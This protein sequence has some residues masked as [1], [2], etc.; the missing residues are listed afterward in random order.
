MKNKS[1]NFLIIASKDQISALSLE[2]CLNT[3]GHAVYRL[4]QN[5]SFL[6]YMIDKNIHGLFI[7]FN[8]SG[9]S[10]LDL[11]KTTFADPRFKHFPIAIF[12][13]DSNNSLNDAFLDIGVSEIISSPIDKSALKQ[14]CRM[15]SNM[16]SRIVYLKE[17]EEY[18]HHLEMES[19]LA[20][21]KLD[22]DFSIIEC[23]SNYQ[24]NIAEKNNNWQ[25]HLFTDY[26]HPLDR[27]TCLQY[28]TSAQG[29]PDPI[30]FCARLRSVNEYQYYSWT[31]TNNEHYSVLTGHNISEQLSADDRNNMNAKIFQEAR[32]ISQITP[33][34]YNPISQEL[35][36]GLDFTFQNFGHTA[37]FSHFIKT[38]IDEDRPKFQAAFHNFVQHHE[39]FTIS[40]KQYVNKELR[41]LF[42][43]GFT[44]SHTDSGKAS[45]IGIIQDI[46]YFNEMSHELILQKS[47]LKNVDKVG[48][49]GR[50][51]LDLKSKQVIIS[52]QLHELIGFDKTP[53]NQIEKVLPH[54]HPDDREKLKKFIISYAQRLPQ[55]DI[56]ECRMFNSVK[57]IKHVRIY[58]ES[59]FNPDTG[60]IIS[61]YG[62]V[63]DISEIHKVKHELMIRE[64]DYKTLFHN[65][66]NPH[67]LA[68]I[69]RDKKGKAY[70]I[71]IIEESLSFKNIFDSKERSLV[72]K[73]YLS[74]TSE[75]SAGL[76]RELAILSLKEDYYFGERY[77]ALTD[78]WFHISIYSPSKDKVIWSLNDISAI[79]KNGNILKQKNR[80]S[81]LLNTILKHI[82]EHI[83]YKDMLKKS[84]PLI[85]DQMN[86]TRV[87]FFQ[88]EKT[89]KNL[90]SDFSYSKT[91]TK[92]YL[93]ANSILIMG[94]HDSVIPLKNKQGLLIINDCFN[95]NLVQTSLVK[96]IK[97]GPIRSLL[98][99]PLIV[100]QSL[101]GYVGV[102]TDHA[103][104][105]N[106]DEISLIENIGFA[107]SSYLEKKMKSDEL[108]YEQRRL[109]LAL[110]INDMVDWEYRVST[111][112]WTFNEHYFDYI[113]R[114]FPG[115]E[116]IK[117]PTFEFIH[118]EDRDKFK[119]DFF[120]FIHGS[121]KVFQNIIRIQTLKKEIKWIYFVANVSQRLAN[122]SPEII[123]GIFQ[124]IT[125]EYIQRRKLEI[126][127]DK[128]KQTS[129]LA[130]IGYWNYS[131]TDKTFTFTA[132]AARI[133]L[134]KR[135]ETIL[136]YNDFITMVPF[137]DRERYI[138]H[139]MAKKSK[140]SSTVKYHIITPKGKEK[141]IHEIRLDDFNSHGYYVT[142][143]G[144]IQDMSEIE[145]VSSALQL[146]EAR[147]TNAI[148][149]VNM[150]IWEYN[151]STKSFVTNHMWF[152]MLGYKPLENMTIS[153]RFWED[154][155]HPEDKPHVLQELGKFIS[156][157]ISI[158]D[159][160]Y[161]MRSHDGSYRWIHSFAQSKSLTSSNIIGFHLDVSDSMRQHQDLEMANNLIQNTHDA[162]YVLDMNGNIIFVNQAV[163][164]MLGYSI[165]SI[166]NMTIMDLDS[167]KE[168]NTIEQYTKRWESRILNKTYV[169]ETEHITSTGKTIPV[170]AHV[171]HAMVENQELSFCILSDITDQKKK[172]QELIRAKENAEIANKAKSNF[173]A[174][175]SHEI[176]TP[177]NA[178]IGYSNLLADKLNEGEMG[179]Y[180]KSI[181]T[182]G[183]NL[184]TLINNILDISK[185]EAQKVSLKEKP[186]Q[187]I[188]LLQE[189]ETIFRIRAEKKMLDF[190]IELPS[191][192]PYL[193]LDRIRIQQILTNLI[194]NAIKFTEEG[195]I[196]ISLTLRQNM[197]RLYS[198]SINVTDT[199]MGIDPINQKKIFQTFEQTDM[200]SELMI[201]GSGLGLSISKQLTELMGGTLSCKSSLGK[202]STFSI[203]L[204]D[205]KG[206]EFKNTLNLLDIEPNAPKI[207]LFKRFKNQQEIILP[208]KITKKE[209]DTLAEMILKLS[210]G[211]NIQ[212]GKKCVLYL[213]KLA[214][215]Y[216]DE[217]LTI[218][219]S[220]LNNSLST[221]DIV[222]IDKIVSEY[223]KAL[224]L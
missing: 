210:A 187:L 197:N 168:L 21:V 146:S 144:V 60:K 156:Q 39:D 51:T 66:H 43:R 80:N 214:K 85:I 196:R 170:E 160:T 129:L 143:R 200:T 184:L 199:G 12:G 11:C 33:W 98:Y 117:E 1:L 46:S 65:L 217:N 75:K 16:V 37:E 213:K 158:Y 26:I 36:F 218:N 15:F 149:G 220:K 56:I 62:I 118:P 76:L 70:D 204:S 180:T 73:N 211:I 138:Q 18:F 135:K 109:K 10:S 115:K 67:L 151:V 176:R 130:K 193:Q 68:Q 77:Y 145:E 72:G 126:S 148:E 50:W 186:V 201:K 120:E 110:Q 8:I 61:V 93:D 87:D 99:A 124:E 91:D 173:I 92:S 154:L 28:L 179:S 181:L 177:L 223:K 40:C 142:S 49:I 57:K 215:K 128:L 53:P 101:W 157:E 19:E 188:E 58:V 59:N 38:F 5:S 174:N 96:N 209:C 216:N 23:N 2:E 20:Y 178:I 133:L 212:I 89:T 153:R 69:I 136:S 161:R 113:K 78:T 32:N 97:K 166:L 183:K 25:A 207:N 132:E 123:A 74:E 167:N 122:N 125:K 119:Q 219:S 44:H 45:Y 83:P 205:V 147:L 190:V 108:E 54:I 141:S 169:Y 208:V 150:G 152:T 159:V 55:S 111:D 189:M 34:T 52:K 14:K 79:K 206:T 41:Y 90:V 127:E 88:V 106:D 121:K 48:Q 195:S 3:M 112:K 165:A 17:N 131:E 137:E 139:F 29:S 47:F 116:K 175:V 63:Q 191:N 107:Y 155:L 94:N 30:N 95:K 103:H 6:N 224:K 105:W 7:D 13:S 100:R 140:K 71:N 171:T 164:K 86:V 185:I 9:S 31:L 81:H 4:E 102:N 84:L 182:A 42:I 192:V 114:F 134:N 162:F 27:Q 222:E 203:H 163:C 64:Q 221:F 24:K 194:E 172:E 198:I 202:G 104:V 22:S 82:L 35:D